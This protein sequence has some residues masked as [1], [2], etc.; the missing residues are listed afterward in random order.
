M[1]TTIEGGKH[2]R[3]A[4]AFALGDE[5]G[6]YKFA[7]GQTVQAIAVLSGGEIYPPAGTSVEGLEVVIFYPYLRLEGLLGGYAVENEWTIHLKQ[8][9]SSKNAIG[10]S[11][12]VLAALGNV[13]SMTKVTANKERGIPEMVQLK[14]HD[15]EAIENG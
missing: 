10:A 12:K 15:F 9:D 4:I 7:N 2:L 13:K 5:I 14:I 8:W 6:T 3:D 11:K 1:L